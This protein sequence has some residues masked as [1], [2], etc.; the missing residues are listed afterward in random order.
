MAT[1]STIP[2][3]KAALVASLRSA[4]PDVQITYGGVENP[5][6]SYIGIGNVVGNFAI[7]TMKAGRK[8]RNETYTIA[9]LI[10]TILATD[11]VEGAEALAYEHLATLEDLLAN[12][13]SFPGVNVAVAGSIESDCGYVLGG[14][15]GC[16]LTLEVA[17]TNRLD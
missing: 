7:P 14:G 11:D 6:E 2:A 15:A 4:L 12:D 1:T 9:V 3:V 8:S 5:Q 16:N 13:P 17:V 10:A